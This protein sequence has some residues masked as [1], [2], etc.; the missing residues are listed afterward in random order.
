[1]NVDNQ[2]I[3]ENIRESIPTAR[4]VE[5]YKEIDQ[6]AVES[7]RKELEEKDVETNIVSTQRYEFE[8]VGKEDYLEVDNETIIYN[9]NFVFDATKPI[10]AF[11]NPKAPPGAPPRTSRGVCA[12]S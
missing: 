7:V 8:L 2:K 5:T 3:W 1:M 10:D 9:R 4:I 12:R 6:L 11:G